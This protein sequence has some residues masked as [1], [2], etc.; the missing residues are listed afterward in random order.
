MEKHGDPITEEVHNVIKVDLLLALMNHASMP[1][2]L[3]LLKIFRVYMRTRSVGAV[4]YLTRHNG[5]AAAG[6]TG[7][8][9]TEAPVGG[10]R[11]GQAH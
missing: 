6:A 10:G 1:T 3:A 2:R 9:R 11:P 4:T 7:L 5:Y 8:L